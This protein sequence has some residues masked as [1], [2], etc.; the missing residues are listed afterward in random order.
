MEYNRLFK[1]KQQLFSIGNTLK[2]SDR[3]FNVSD[4]LILSYTFSLSVRNTGSAFF[5]I[6]RK[7]LLIQKATQSAVSESSP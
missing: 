2:H 7:I 6:K 3:E 5:K 4:H 1:K